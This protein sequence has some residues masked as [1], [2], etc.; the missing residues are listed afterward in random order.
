MTYFQNM[1]IPPKEITLTDWHCNYNTF[2]PNS[3]GLFQ[4]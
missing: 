4:S 2:T 1:T 3:D